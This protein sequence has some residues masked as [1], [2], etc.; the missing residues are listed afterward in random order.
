MSVMNGEACPIGS[1]TKLGLRNT[2]DKHPLKL[3]VRSKLAALRTIAAI[4][5]G[6][7]VSSSENFMQAYMNSFA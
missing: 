7:N 3:R 5:L 4:S 2:A 6:L 1:A